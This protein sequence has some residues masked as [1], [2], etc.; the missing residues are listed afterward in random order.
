MVL[1]QI[2]CFVAVEVAEREFARLWLPLAP[3][4]V[5]G[6]KQHPLLF[7]LCKSVR[8]CPGH[9]EQGGGSGQVVPLWV[10][11]WQPQLKGKLRTVTLLLH[12]R[13]AWW[14]GNPADDGG[15][16]VDWT[17]DV[18]SWLWGP[19]RF[20]RWYSGVP[21]RWW[22]LNPG[23]IP[24]ILVFTILP[25]LPLWTKDWVVSYWRLSHNEF[26]DIL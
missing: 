1:H 16:F 10:G 25:P 2:P 22:F 11:L 26:C 24:G 3:L 23:W 21:G 13:T 5:L 18:I 19:F 15:G 8:W 7:S 12:D 17:F 4:L 6:R 14:L 20:S 9:S